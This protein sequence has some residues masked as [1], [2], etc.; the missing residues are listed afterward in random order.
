MRRTLSRLL[1]GTMLSACAALPALAQDSSPYATPSDDADVVVINQV[2]LGNVFANMN[3]VVDDYASDAEVIATATGNTST[4]STLD[5]DIDYDATQTQSGSVSASTSLTG[6]TVYGDG[7]STVTTA[8]G[9][10]ASS[11]SENGR[12][13]HRATQES[14]A[15]V[16]AYSE[17]DLLV[18]DDVDA[19]TT[20]A[21][22][23]SNHTNLYGDNRGFQQQTGNANVYATTTA[24]FD[25]IDDSGRFGSVATGNNHSATGSTSTSYTGVV[26][27][28]ADSTEVAAFTEAYAGYGEDVAVGA[29]ASGNSTE[30]NN[31]WGFATLGRDGSAVSQYNGAE[32]AAD[33]SLTLT[34]WT[35]FSGATSYG[36]GNSAL[37]SNIGS[38]TQMFVNQNNQG[39]V[40]TTASFDGGASDGSIGYASA[41]SIG[42]AAT[43][44][45]CRTCGDNPVLSGRTNQVNGND[46][47]AYGYVNS[48][49]NGSAYGAATAVGNSATYQ[50]ISTSDD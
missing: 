16:T 20:A 40:Q 24:T 25:S 29:T 34:N 30:V 23:V 5:N 15:D 4:A 1:A 21:G 17:I 33:T 32:I 50:S 28:M 6:G 36:V 2:T 41:T 26:Q 18:V 49:F 47:S 14:N 48:G 12:T 39:Y 19:T 45:L 3:V 27:R 35:G 44:T 11:H 10:A 9:N 8:Y 42:N 43:A 38:D 7:A 46:V 31:E 37:V 13:F 22:N